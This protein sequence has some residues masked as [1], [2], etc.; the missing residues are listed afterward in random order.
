MDICLMLILFPYSEKMRQILI[1][2][3][4]VN[5]MGPVTIK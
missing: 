2:S 1:Y 3:M 5:N 4:Q